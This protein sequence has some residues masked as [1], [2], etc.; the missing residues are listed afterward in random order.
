M[1][2]Q[3][4]PSSARCRFWRCSSASGVWPELASGMLWDRN[5]QGSIACAWPVDSRA[6]ENIHVAV[7]HKLKIVWVVQVVG[8]SAS[9]GAAD[10]VSSDYPE[11]K[12]S[13]FDGSMLSLYKALIRR[14]LRCIVTAGDNTCRF[15][16]PAWSP[17]SIVALVVESKGL[18][19]NN[20]RYN[21]LE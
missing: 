8:T 7:M 19:N 21:C 12:S 13:R 14:L 11:R 15:A 1:H 5:V 3:E 18:K 9:L 2:V 4:N 16:E 20:S 17:L 10:P 6:R